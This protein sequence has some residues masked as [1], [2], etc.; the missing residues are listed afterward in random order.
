MHND[1]AAMYRALQQRGLASDQILCLEGQLDR[2]LLLSFLAAIGQRMAG[3]TEGAVL[4]Y[5]TGHGFFTGDNATE[6]RV[7]IELQPA[8]QYR[9]E[10]HIYWDELFAA[11]AIPPGVQ[12][13]L[14]PDH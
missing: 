10:V 4:L 8:A 12:M 6:A 14:L 9:P 7:G 5:I 11:L 13:L 2:R 3:W 1:V